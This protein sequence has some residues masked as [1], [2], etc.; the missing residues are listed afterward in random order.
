MKNLSNLAPAK[1]STNK[2]KRRRGR[3]TGSGLGRTAGRGHKGAQSRSG[4]KRRAWFEGGQMPIHRRLPKRGFHNLFR[5]ENQEVNIRDLAKLAG[6]GEVEVTPEVLVAARVI[7]Y[8][9]RPVKLLSMGEA[10]RKYVVRL[11]AASKP[12][13]AKI[14]QAGGQVHLPEPAPKRTKYKK[15]SERGE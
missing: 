5:E 13:V 7:K 10:E 14:E 6:D 8:P 12:A 4:F 9:D 1:G 15:R 11:S 3:G 2:N